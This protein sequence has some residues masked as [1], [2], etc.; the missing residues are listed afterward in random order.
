MPAEPENAQDPL[1][2][3]A[4]V[5]G[6]RG[7]L[8]AAGAVLAAGIGA[9]AD[10]LAHKELTARHGRSAAPPP[11]GAAVPFHGPRQAGVTTSQQPATQLLAFDL[12]QTTVAAGRQT[13]R[14]VLDALTRTLADAGSEAPS[15]L[16]LAGGGTT[17]LSSLV[18]VGPALATRLSLDVPAGFAELPA[19]PGDRLDP[20]RGG[21]D[22]LVQ[23][24]AADRWTL[25]VVAELVGTA[26]RSAGA[27]PRWTQSGFLSPTAPGTTPRNL[28]GFKDGTA[29]PDAAQDEQFVWG[30]PGAHQNGTVL[31]YRRIRMDVAGF[32]A[33]PGD[34]RER[35]IGRRAGD[36]VPL[37]GTAEHDDPDIYAKNPDGSYVIPADAHV[38]LTSPRLD[39]GA[40][41]LRRSYSYDDGPADRGLLFCA[42]M[43]DPGQ[44]VR[45]QDRLATRDALAPFL[46]HQAS[47]VAYVLPGAADGGSLGD[48]LW[49]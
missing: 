28:F 40:R 30:P 9:A 24:C 18:G 49:T 3:A 4:T 14:G 15:D 7:A 32:A 21:G 48:R 16:R 46:Q 39:G 8:L 20:A 35:M 22:L 45:V 17:R 33:L 34:R 43:R 36:G 29:N 41:M 6:R 42:F 44:F 26:A 27:L 25:T 31:V 5:L 47:A 2:P 10:E 12:P 19:F 23:L 11:E 38:R 1:P 13:L 37:T